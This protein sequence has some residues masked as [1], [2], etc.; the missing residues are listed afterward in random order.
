MGGRQFLT[1]HLTD[2]I[3]LTLPLFTIKSKYR[4]GRKICNNFIDY[5]HY[6]IIHITVF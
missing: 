6:V 5:E 2:K 3:M 4:K 1:I